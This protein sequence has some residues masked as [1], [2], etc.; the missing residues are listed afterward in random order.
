MYKVCQDC[1]SSVIVDRG[2]C[3]VCL[4]KYNYEKANRSYKKRKEEGTI[5][6]YGIVICPI[7]KKEMVKNKPEQRVH[8]E[9]TEQLSFFKGNY[10]EV[11]NGG[12]SKKIAVKMVED[13][14]KIELPK[15]FVVHHISCDPFEN[16]LYNFAILKNK[17]HG[18]FHAILRV[19]RLKMIMSGVDN[20]LY[21]WKTFA[22]KFFSSWKNNENCVTI[23]DNSIEEIKE[24]MV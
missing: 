13:F 1:G 6:R 5:K 14:L 12:K 22:I 8:R 4:D 24:F 15:N 19:E 21:D 3:Q 17:V 7:C 2:R 11:P 20:T 9:C 16:E 23:K 10:D 18:Q